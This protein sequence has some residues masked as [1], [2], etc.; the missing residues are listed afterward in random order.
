MAAEAAGDFTPFRGK[1]LTGFKKGIAQAVRSIDSG[2]A[3]KKLEQ[4]IELTNQGSEVQSSMFQRF[5]TQN[6][7]PRTLNG[8]L[9]TGALVHLPLL[10]N[11]IIMNSV[12]SRIIEYKKEE[13]RQLKRQA[14]FRDLRSLTGQVKIE[15]FKAQL[16]D[17]PPPRG[18]KKAITQGKGVNIIAEVKHASPSAGVLIKDFDPLSIANDYL[19]GGA[20]ALS[21]LTEQKFFKGNLDFISLIKKE[22]PLPVLRKDFIID[23]YQIYESR[24]CG[25]DAILLIVSV[26]PKNALKDFLSLSSELDMDTLVEIHDEREL[27][28]AMN[29]GCDII[30][31]NNRNLQTLEV[32]I[33]TTVKLMGC[34]AKGK[35][36]VSESGIKSREDV[37]RLEEAGVKTVLIG[38]ALIRAADRVVMLRELR[39]VKN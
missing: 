32:D 4:L 3:L 14:P 12:L 16:L 10:S 29:V 13:V 38:E 6:G 27:A 33:T 36:V 15:S 8:E 30:G 22:N 24:V 11:G 9:K 26:L 37:I 5:R 28:I 17:C 21:V 34:I 35:V 18:F 1:S 31:I 39:G 2:A 23:H 19:K 7:E 20:V 25:A